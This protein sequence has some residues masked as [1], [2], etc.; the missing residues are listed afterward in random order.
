MTKSP[1]TRIVATVVLVGGLA[2]APLLNK[3]ES[4]GL[5]VEGISPLPVQSPHFQ[6]RWQSGALSLS[7]HTTSFGHELGL[8]Q[9]ANSSYPEGSVRTDFQALGIVPPHWEDTT[10]QVLY[11]LAQSVSAQAEL[12]GNAVSIRAVTNDE[13]GWN[14]R[15]AAVKEALPPRVSINADAL[16]VD[17]AIN[18]A[19][20]CKREF[21]SFEVGPI[22]FEESSA[23]FRSSAL[24]RLDRV[25]ALANACSY[26][27]ISITGHTDSSGSASGNQ[28]LSLKR[29]NAVGDYVV[30]GG[31]D[32]TRLRVSGAGSSKP[33]ADDSTRYGRS[34]NRRIEIT[35]SN[36][37]QAAAPIN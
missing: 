26:S 6:F 22:N 33:I 24:P 14:S 28:R 8:L 3:N 5:S 13:L 25:I 29:A 35:L 16:F 1:A 7:G 17:P 37:D 20:V 19:E 2:V 4:S 18:L 12:S 21:T 27:T 31:V 9:V 23:D 10:I 30:A 36:T 32:R 11:L 15:L 34:L